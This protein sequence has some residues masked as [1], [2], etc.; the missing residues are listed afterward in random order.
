MEVNKQTTLKQKFL[1]L[2][3]F[4]SKT[5]ATQAIQ[6]QE[7][8]GEDSSTGSSEASG[9]VASTSNGNKSVDCVEAVP[10][11]NDLFNS[12]VCLSLYSACCIWRYKYNKYTKKLGIFS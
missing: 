12:I 6:N 9:T 11:L 10:V 1:L 3:W 7:D 5:S 8:A 4:K 2:G